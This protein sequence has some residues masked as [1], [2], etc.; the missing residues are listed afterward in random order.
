MLR[1]LGRLIG[2]MAL[3]TM[4]S[5][6]AAQ[7]PAKDPQANMY[8]VSSPGQNTLVAK[9]PTLTACKAAATNWSYNQLAGNP[10]TTSLWVA[11]VCLPIE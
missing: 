2:L 6:A 9:F 11:A 3:F 1:G 10:Q 4:V 5:A 8:L 7:T